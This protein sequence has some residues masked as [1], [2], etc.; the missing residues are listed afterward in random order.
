MATK[1]KD[2]FDI[3]LRRRMR[4]TVKELIAKLQDMDDEVKDYK[5]GFEIR[6]NITKDTSVVTSSLNIEVPEECDVDNEIFWISV[7]DI[8]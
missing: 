7:G 4:V 2:W 5:V 3:M 1:K 8:Q 6:V